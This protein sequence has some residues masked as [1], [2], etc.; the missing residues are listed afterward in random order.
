MSDAQVSPLFP[1]GSGDIRLISTDGT[2]FYV[3][4]LILRLASPFFE[5]MFEIGSEGTPQSNHLP[6]RVEADA[7]TLTCLLQYLYPTPCRPRITDLGQLTATLRTAKRYEME[8]VIEQLRSVLTE[9]YLEEDELIVPLYIRYP[10]PVLLIADAFGFIAEKRLALRECLEG[11][12]TEHLKTVIS[13]DI[14][15]RIMIGLLE[16][17]K[18]RLEWFRSKL[19]AWSPP[20]VEPCCSQKFLEH[21]QKIETKVYHCLEFQPFVD[22][23]TKGLRCDNQKVTT[24]SFIKGHLIAVPFDAVV[25]RW[26]REWVV[27]RKSIPKV[28]PIM[29]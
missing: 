29:A 7:K 28:P 14:P 16:L 10:L 21:R 25:Q 1:A 18:E 6:L 19:N 27:L 11:D 2:I 20:L 22:E 13:S 23:L 17:R 3:H 5:T 26:E 4:R 24:S 9:R 8:G 12:L 15:A